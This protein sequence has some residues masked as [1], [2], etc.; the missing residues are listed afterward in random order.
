MKQ[1]TLLRDI[2]DIHQD[3]SQIFTK[4]IIYKASI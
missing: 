4:K 1:T 2:H 3:H